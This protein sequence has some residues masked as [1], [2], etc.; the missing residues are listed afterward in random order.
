MEHDIVWKITGI[1][2]QKCVRLIREG[3]EDLPGTGEVMVSKEL[4]T[5]AVRYSRDKLTPRQMQDVIQNLVNGKFTAEEIEPMYSTNSYVIKGD[6]VEKEEVVRR[7]AG[8]LGVQATQEEEGDRIKVTHNQ[9]VLTKQQLKDA[10]DEISEATIVDVN[11]I[12]TIEVRGMT[13]HRCVDNIQTKVRDKP[14]INNIEVN[15]DNASAVVSYDPSVTAPDI[16]AG[17]IMDCNPNKF[18]ATVMPTQNR[19]KPS[20]TKK[21]RQAA[22]ARVHIDG[23][24]CGKCVKHIETKMSTAVGVMSVRVNLEEKMGEIE[25]DKA[26]TTSNNIVQN[27][28]NIGTKFTAHL[29]AEVCRLRVDGMTCQS[30]VRNITNTVEAVDGVMDCSISLDEKLAVVQFDPNKTNSDSLLEAINGMGTKFTASYESASTVVDIPSTQVSVG[31]IKETAAKDDS[32]VD[33]HKCWLRVQGMTCASCVAAIEKHGE[34]IDGVKSVLVALMAAKAEVMYDP[35]IVL[36]HQIADSITQLGFPT[37]VLED[38]TSVGDVQISIKGMTCSSCVH[39]IESGLAKFEGVRAVTVALTTERGKV[40]FDPNIIG[41]RDIVEAVNNMG[42]TANIVGKDTKSNYLDHKEDIR[43]W[44]SSFFIS[45]VFGLP[46]MVI[47]MYFMVEMSQASHKHEDDCCVVPGLSLENLLL[48]LLS[49]PVQFIGGRYFYI[50]AW[51]AV[52]HGTSNMDVLVVLAT[53]ISYLYS[54]A[55]VTASMIMQETSSPVTFF[56]TPPMLFVFISLGRW[57]EHIAK[58]KTSDALAKLM[59]LKATDAVLVQLGEDGEVVTEKTINVELLHR[60][61]VLKV[62][63]GY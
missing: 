9:L 53:T 43:K 57:L 41:P 3:L 22:T 13:C 6:D 58:A 25:F 8:K 30:C 5:A 38:E 11:R 14:G 47:M 26:A 44:R 21:H 45:L 50:Q 42:F 15:L 59:S 33:Y 56:D 7:L 62:R 46:C 35:S 12:V 18:T 52:R 1:T 17:Y 54:C 51:A 27:V 28:N 60:G 16:I 29:V 23:M 61:D 37:N 10:V 4:S 24:T 55:V 49:T 40:K 36:P 19:E 2:C 20:D 32:D 63:S 31:I 39:L 48:F 34:K